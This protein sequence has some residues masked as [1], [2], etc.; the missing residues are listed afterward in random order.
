MVNDETNNRTQRKFAKT[1]GPFSTTELNKARNHVAEETAKIQEE[2]DGPNPLQSSQSTDINDLKNTGEIASRFNQ[3]LDKV[4]D[5]LLILILKFGR[6][7]SM[8]VVVLAGIAIAITVMAINTVYLVSTRSDIESLLDEMRLVQKKQTALLAKSEEALARSISA[9]KEAREAKE[10]APEIIINAEGQTALI[11]KGE[12][13]A[14]KGEPVKVTGA[15]K[16]TTERSRDSSRSVPK[17]TLEGIEFPL[18]L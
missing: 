17:R 13:V 1:M 16:P 5:V 11:V 12:P 6:A 3:G 8:L 2:E 15:S 10:S 9:E 14:V 18:D 4:T 7:S